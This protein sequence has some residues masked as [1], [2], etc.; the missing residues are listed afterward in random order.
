MNPHTI[1][2]ALAG[3]PNTGKSTVF[4]ALTGLSQKIGNFPGVTVDKRSGV[5]QLNGALHAEITD[6]PGT[7]SLYPRSADEHIAINLLTDPHNSF[8]PDVVIIVADASNLKRNLLLFTQIA[9]LQI[10]VILALNMMDAAKK[11]G[12]SI[13]I[14][15]LSEKLGIPVIGMN[16]RAGEGFKELKEALAKEL[17][18]VS[19]P[20]IEFHTIAP[21]LIEEIKKKFAVKNDYIAFELTHHFEG[22]RYLK[23]EDKAWLREILNSHHF[24][25]QKTQAKE[26]IARYNFI[27]DLLYDCV[28]RAETVQQETFSNKLDKLLTHK[29]WGFAIFLLILFLVF[30]SIFS[31]AQYPMDWIEQGFLA[32]NRSLKSLLPAGKLTDLLT[33]GVLAGLSG[34]VVFIPQIVILFAFTAVLEDTG[35]MARV[36]F[37]MDRL[38]KKVGLNGKSV[39]PLMSGVACAVPAIMATRTIENWKDRIIT[40]MVTPLMSC[41]ARLP[42]YTLL[43]ALVIPDTG[44]L[45]IFNLQGLTLM[46]MYLLGFVAAISA[47]VVLKKIIRVKEKSYF[48]MELP[49]YRLPRWS[50]I[51]ITLFN[52]AR[53]FVVE[54]GRVIVAVSIVLWVLASYAPGD[55]FE[56][57]EK[58]YSIE[59]ITEETPYKINAEKLEASYAGSLGRLIEPA[60]QPLGYDWK[61]GIALITSFAA[62]EVFVGTMATIYSVQGDDTNTASVKAKMR[63]AKNVTTGQ[64]VF[65]FAV[66]FSLMI[67]YA[68]AM[69]CMSTFAVVYRETKSWKWPVIQLVYMSC[70]AYFAA[71]AIYQL[72]K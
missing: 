25:A 49:V 24:D 70:M 12:V 51:G 27:N 30:Q 34:V 28:S 72:L 21:E 9:D 45:G 1:K 69:Q 41:S 29:I 33:D 2:V 67:F 22:L 53:T 47:S 35:Y 4:N 15:L 13:N 63:E 52:Q 38:M 66:A 64:P 57:I 60:I 54:A 39:V 42:V 19:S 37:M 62:R 16:A 58:K 20:T 11:G 71:L 40:I 36:S 6:L 3:N 46:M 50:N 10:P 17:R 23:K 68:F 61:I 48:M 56:Q 32:I 14:P 18:P 55:K 43:I 5:C 31:F 8:H 44:V 7:Y 65:T 59:K 26:T